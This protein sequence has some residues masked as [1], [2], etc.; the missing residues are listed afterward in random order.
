MR[1]RDAREEVYKGAWLSWGTKAQLTKA[2]EEFAETAAV[3]NRAQNDQAD[4]DEIIDE[5]A[6]AR[7]MLEQLEWQFDDDAVD[8][9]IADAVA[10]LKHRVE[11]HDDA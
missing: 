8:E 5:L 6:D 10:D 7:L 11:V 1:S 3:I 9:A 4:L 2:A